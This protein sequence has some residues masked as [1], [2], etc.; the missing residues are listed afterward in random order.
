M[1]QGFSTCCCALAKQ[2]S[3]VPPKEVIDLMPF[4]RTEEQHKLDDPSGVLIQEE[5]NIQYGHEKSEDQPFREVPSHQSP[6]MSPREAKRLEFTVHIQ[7]QSETESLGMAVRRQAAEPCHLEVTGINGG[8]VAAWNT[9]NPRKK[10]HV[11]DEL[12][13][14]N[15][16]RAQNAL[17][18]LDLI[19][20]GTSLQLVFRRSALPRSDGVKASCRGSQ[21]RSS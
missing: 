10:V 12:L 7:R 21:N 19:K 6:L 3:G 2:A 15:G 16:M 20:H 17:D 8:C 1:L 4:A 11:G 13:E 14:V 9:Q 5:G 18:L